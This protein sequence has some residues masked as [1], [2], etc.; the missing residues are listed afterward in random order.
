MTCLKSLS[1][2]AASV[3]VTAIRLPVDVIDGSKLLISD[4]VPFKIWLGTGRIVVRIHRR[5]VMVGTWCWICV[6]YVCMSVCMYVCMCVCVCMYVC[7]YVCVHVCVY[8]YMYVC[9][10]VCACMYVCMYVCIRVF[11]YTLFTLHA[12]L[13]CSNTTYMV[14]TFLYSSI[15][16]LLWYGYLLLPY[17][18]YILQ[19]YYVCIYVCMYM[20][21]YMYVCMYKA[22][23][24]CYQFPVMW[25]MAEARC[26]KVLVFLR[27]VS[28]R[29]ED[30]VESHVF[31]FVTIWAH[32]K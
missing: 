6:M 13:L 31:S 25:L 30:T 3:R 14:S 10:Y 19:T 23:T 27:S 29:G 1:S 16:F 4:R 21:V 2:A 24:T 15:L 5:T 28:V 20:C 9:M 17:S 11:I 18:I 12:P 26:K 8:V 22:Q 32:I 7:M